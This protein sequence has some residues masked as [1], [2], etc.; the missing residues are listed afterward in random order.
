MS[1][2]GSGEAERLPADF[3]EILRC[4]NDAHPRDDGVVRPEGDFLVCTV[5]GYR[6]KVEDGI[7]NFLWEDAIPPA[8]NPSGG[9]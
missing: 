4:V 5:C 2:A 9:A 7:P 6:Y 1:S 8:S 3:V